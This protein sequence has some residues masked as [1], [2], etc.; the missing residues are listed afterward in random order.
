V[1]H[2]LDQ[3]AQLGLLEN[4]HLDYTKYRAAL[5]LQNIFFTNRIHDIWNELHGSVVD[6]ESV[7]VFKKRLRSVD[8]SACLR[9][10]CFISV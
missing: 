4:T 7:A 3:F 10:P 8:I 2:Y 6:S 1:T 5:M 9:Y